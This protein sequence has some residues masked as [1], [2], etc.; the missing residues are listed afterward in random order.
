MESIVDSILNESGRIMTDYRGLLSDIAQQATGLRKILLDEGQIVKL[1][2]HSAEQIEE[3]SLCSID[4]AS[5]SEK[6]QSGDLMIAGSSLHDG[7]QSKIVYEDDEDVPS[8]SFADIRLHSSKNDEVLSAMRAYTEIAVLGAANDHDMVIIDG[9]YLG[10]FSTVIFALQESKETAQR[11]IEALG[12][13]SGAFFISG[14]RKILNLT[15]KTSGSQEIVALAKSDSSNEIVKELLP[16]GSELITSDKILAG[17]LLMPGEILRPRFINKTA[18][19]PDYLSENVS[20]PEYGWKGF[21]WPVK[22]VLGAVE[23]Q[24]LEVLFALADDITQARKQDND[25]GMF[26]QLTYLI[27]ENNLHYSYFKPN[28]FEQGSHALRLESTTLRMQGTT[29][30]HLA[31]ATEQANNLAAYIDADVISPAIKEPYS[32]YMVD[33]IVKKPVSSSMKLLKSILANGL[34]EHGDPMNALSSYRS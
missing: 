32:Q 24:R 9:A 28:N 12:E 8:F 15:L 11:L 22:T 14:V 31:R 7:A 19:K 16:S 30:E 20:S 21:K 6:L 1:P 29:A 4:G 5:A 10:N 3:F 33:Q 23:Y 25:N 27:R 13:E 34:A 18:V 2:I 17:Y 26:S